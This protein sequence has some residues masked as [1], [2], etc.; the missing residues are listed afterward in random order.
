[1]SMSMTIVTGAS[2]A[3]TT[4]R[5]RDDDARVTTTG[6]RARRRDG[7]ARAFASDEGENAAKKSEIALAD[8]RKG[9]K[10]GSGS[11]GDVFEG[12]WRGRAV[13]LKEPRRLFGVYL[14]G[15]TF[16]EIE[17]ENNR[18]LRGCASAATFLG[19]A[20]AYA[21]L[22]W[23]DEGRETL[24]DALGG[25]FASKLGCSTDEEAARKV[26]REM[27]KCVKDV[28]AKQFIHRDVKPNNLLITRGG[29]LKLIDFGGAAD[30]KTGRNYD[31]DETVFDPTYGPPERYL[32]GKLSK[33]AKN[34]PD[35]FDAF[36]C[37][38]T[39]LQVSVPS[40]RKRG[41]MT[42]VRR[43]LKKF[44]YDCEAWRAS[45]PERRQGEFAILDANSGAGWKVVC[46]L[47]APRD[48]RMSVSKALS[49]PFCK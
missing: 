23:E 45:L 39:I 10:I 48:N 31:E 19:V 12:A 17:A 28:H 37:G 9:R 13:V 20:G 36:S 44:D 25:G 40:F 11:F 7:V 8:V 27:L 34:K 22:V 47:V 42:A 32:K 35:L 4:T 43:D 41:G 14:G 18:R 49:S 29:K 15:G 33:V 5:R 3:W 16:L 46:G 6:R 2:R 24:E 38:M 1:M 21:Y 26:A 30:L